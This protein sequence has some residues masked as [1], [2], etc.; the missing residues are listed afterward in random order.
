GV[1]REGVRDGSWVVC[2]TRYWRKRAVGAAITACSGSVCS[3]DQLLQ[4]SSGSEVLPL[5]TATVTL[6][7]AAVS[8]FQRREPHLLISLAS[9]TSETMVPEGAYLS[10]KT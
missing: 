1:R 5:R 9:S 10:C 4:V 7:A 3:A 2:I 6:V 8:A